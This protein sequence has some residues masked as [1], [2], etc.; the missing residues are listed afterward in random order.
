MDD[1]LIHITG[2]L[3]V[4]KTKDFEEINSKIMDGLYD[5]GVEEVLTM[6]FEEQLDGVEE[7]MECTIKKELLFN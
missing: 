5:A 4:K 2:T 1:Y 6:D 7:Y 3:R